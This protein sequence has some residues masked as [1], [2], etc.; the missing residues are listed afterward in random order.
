MQGVILAVA[1]IAI[2]LGGA[3]VWLAWAETTNGAAEI[4][5]VRA[6]RGPFVFSVTE[7][8]EVESSSNVEIRCEV[9]ARGGAGT[10]ILEIVPE[11][12][13]VQEGDFLAKLDSS[14]LELDMNSQQIEVHT[15]EASMIQAQNAYETAKIAKTEYLEGTFKQEELTIR[16]EV[17]VAKETLRRAEEYL[18][19]S[20]QLAAKGY[21]TELQLD[22]DRFAVDKAKEDLIAAQSKLNVLREYTKA[23][24][25]TQLD[26]DIQTA[27]AQWQSAKS[28]YDLEVGKLQEIETQIADCTIAAPSV[29]QVKYANKRSYRGSSEVIIEPGT[30]IRQGQV[31]VRLPDPSKMQVE[32]DI[33]ENS[34]KYVRSGLPAT[35]LISS[36]SAE[37][38]KGQ[39][40]K[41]ND[42]PEPSGFFSSNVKRYETLIEILENPGNLKPGLTAEVTIEVDSRD[43]VLQLPLQSVVEHGDEFYC[44]LKTSNGWELR[45][46][47]I[48]LSNDQT[49]EILGGIAESDEVAANPRPHR[50]LVEWPEPVADDDQQ[51]SEPRRQ[52][53]SREGESRE[54][55]SREGGPRGPQGG[56][57]RQT[58]DPA[59][60]VS[61]ILQ[62]FD[63]D[64]D[65]RLN[66]EELMTAPDR[67]RQR[68][69]QADANGDGAVDRAELMQSMRRR[70]ESR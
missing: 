26:S 7:T 2:A 3:Y 24:M 66:A 50:H 39:V 33:N 43:N 5:T 45:E 52:P 61:D 30:Q 41:V 70:E 57:S 18:Q 25:L 9:K 67:I 65:G 64:G 14:A 37:P 53:R 48:G 23:K 31:I 21:V 69:A 36:I 56:P 44:L 38:L 40:V 4:E 51:T 8:G 11:G 20:E 47:Q 17:F 68:L 59:V 42:Y 58:F 19:Y 22:A 12:T 54:G 62:R 27:H 35:V 16:G 34:T 13:Y 15:S 46:L 28:R 6:N 10:T 60:A 49:V 32:A 29:G 63:Q 55:E 1:L